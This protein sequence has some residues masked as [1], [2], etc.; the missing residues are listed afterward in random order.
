MERM[1]GPRHLSEALSEL[2]ARRGLAR[3]Q[4]DQQL[5]AAWADVAGPEIAGR[6]RVLDVRR[7]VLRVAVA[8]AALLSELVGFRSMELLNK[9]REKYPEFKVKDMK[10]LLRG[11]IRG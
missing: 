5:H 1:A 7:G 11:D 6:T 9:L 8:H 10:F 4:G 2:I 3:V